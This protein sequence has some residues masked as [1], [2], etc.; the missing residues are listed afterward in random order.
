MK[1]D[2]LEKEKKEK[3]RK[4]SRYWPKFNYLSQ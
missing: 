1:I 4:R 3:K 2:R